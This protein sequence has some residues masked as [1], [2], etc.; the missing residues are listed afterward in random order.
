[1]YVNLLSIVQNV[2]S[3]GLAAAVSGGKGLFRQGS[4]SEVGELFRGGT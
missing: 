1:M 4:P 2:H 3:P